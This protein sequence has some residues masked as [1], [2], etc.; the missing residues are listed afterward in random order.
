MKKLL[1]TFASLAMALTVVTPAVA[2]VVPGPTMGDNW[3]G[4]AVIAIAGIGFLVVRQ[5]RRKRGA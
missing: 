5:L 4:I 3:A 1:T 2:G